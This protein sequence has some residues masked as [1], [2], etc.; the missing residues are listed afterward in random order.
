MTHQ[1]AQ[2]LGVYWIFGCQHTAADEDAEQ[3]KVAEPWM[4]Y[5][6]VAHQTKPANKTQKMD[7]SFL[8]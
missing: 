2:T 6:T 4:H 3:Y 5:H 1:I 8:T 7:S